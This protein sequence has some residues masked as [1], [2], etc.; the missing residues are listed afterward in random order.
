[1]VIRQE[2][3][4]RLSQR[5][6]HKR[7]LRNTIRIQAFVRGCLC[8]QRVGTIVSSLILELQRREVQLNSAST[9]IQAIARGYLCR[10]RLRRRMRYQSEL[11]TGSDSSYYHQTAQNNSSYDHH[12]KSSES[13]FTPEILSRYPSSGSLSS[14]LY[15]PPRVTNLI[16]IFQASPLAYLDANREPRRVPRIDLHFERETITKALKGSNVS[17]D[18]EIAID[19]RF[20]AFLAKD[21]CRAIHFSCHGHPTYLAFEDGWGAMQCLEASVL[22]RWIACGGSQLQFVFV[23]AC[24]SWSIGKAFAEAGVP[25]VVC[26]DK[27]TTL[28]DSGAA[29]KFTKALYQALAWGKT[30][31]KAFDLACQELSVYPCYGSQ[32]FCL[33]PENSNHNVP[34]FS[35]DLP[36]SAPARS[37]DD[38]PDLPSPTDFFVRD[39]LEMYRTIQA[40]KN[41][42]VVRVKGPAGIGKSTLVM[43]CCRYLSDRQEVVNLDDIHWKSV[44]PDKEEPINTDF[45]ATCFRM[46]FPQWRNGSS[47]TPAI[48]EC[49][50]NIIYHYKER[51]SLLVIEAKML[52]RRGI[53]KMHSFLKRLIE[54]TNHLKLVVIYGGH[55]DP[56]NIGD[57][58]MAFDIT[59]D[60]LNI[61]STVKL[62][63]R[64]C[65]HVP[66]R[67]YPRVCN[68]GDLW[69]L[70]SILLGSLWLC[71]VRFS[72]PFCLLIYHASFLRKAQHQ[73][74]FRNVTRRFSGC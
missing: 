63:A 24:D 48:R 69:R 12:N 73:V 1:M 49:R 39:D 35:R 6:H 72:H 33:L 60:S 22:K 2:R 41:T 65:E 42:R 59:V 47:T 46:L 5:S 58:S 7:L 56:D 14:L 25:H 40:I 53:K 11:L 68:C 8:R 45:L 74:I 64:Y 17:V 34:I 52:S 44:N 54:G 29:V 51:R 62:F 66:N 13:Y 26:C 18:F 61:E 3:R 31:Q 19:D 9:Q 55:V 50:R 37:T 71:F 57:L 21:E 4:K 27:Q 15:A 16:K 30:L 32:Q 23:S 70:V 43:E 28:L 67:V 20:G 38:S 10:R 36:G